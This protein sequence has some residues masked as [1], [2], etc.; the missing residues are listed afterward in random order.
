MSVLAPGGFMAWD[1]PAYLVHNL[2]H[3]LVIL[4]LG[5]TA[6]ATAA[7]RASS[8][9]CVRVGVPVKEKRAVQM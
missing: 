1:F 4:V 8:T 5:R 9:H 3:V 6:P 7:F 2:V